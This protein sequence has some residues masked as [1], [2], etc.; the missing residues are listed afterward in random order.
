MKGKNNII[1]KGAFLDMARKNNL[2]PIEVV[3]DVKLSVQLTCNEEAF[4]KLA[5]AKSSEVFYFFEYPEDYEVLITGDTFDF[6][7]DRIQEMIEYLDISED[8]LWDLDREIYPDMEDD[9]DDEYEDDGTLEPYKPTSLEEKLKNEILVYNAQVNKENLTIPRRF[10]AFYVDC[11]CFIG[12]YKNKE[13]ETWS[14]AEEKL[15]SILSV[16]KDLVEQNKESAENKKT[17]IRERLKKHL[18]NDAQFK[19]STNK[20]LRKEYADSLWK[21]KEFAWI[22]EGFSKGYGDYPANEYYNFIERVY[23]EIKYFRTSSIVYQK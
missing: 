16:H 11:G 1:E 4:L 5:A 15:Y 3:P 22:K 2:T 23:N 7:N 19:I 8:F 14:I 18:K 6:A 20:A 17:D 13:T 21:N 9:E 10:M 12:V